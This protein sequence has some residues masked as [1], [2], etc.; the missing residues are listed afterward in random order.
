[1][2]RAQSVLLIIASV[3]YIVPQVYGMEAAD[4]AYLGSLPGMLISTENLDVAR[5]ILWLSMG[6]IA[7]TGAGIFFHF[8]WRLGRPEEGLPSSH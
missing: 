5:P 8:L 2:F 6:L 7:L 4:Q 1:M 3:L